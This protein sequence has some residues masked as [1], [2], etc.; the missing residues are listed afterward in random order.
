VISSTVCASLFIDA[1]YSI[2][3]YD[4]PKLAC[5]WLL[6]G[7]LLAVCL[8]FALISS[9]QGTLYGIN[10]DAATPETKTSAAGLTV[11]MQNIIGFAFGPLVPSILA[12]V[13]GG[14]IATLCPWLEENSVRGVQFA[15]GM[16]C[17][18]LAAWPLLYFVELATRA[19][20]RLP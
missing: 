6:A 19:A 18:L 5:G 11:S 4:L 20:K 7:V 9:L 1:A 10:T 12:D 14:L 3:H 15:I 16:A 8:V 13:A 2:V 17:A